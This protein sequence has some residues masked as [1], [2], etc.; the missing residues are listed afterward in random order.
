MGNELKWRPKFKNQQNFI[1]TSI[2]IQIALLKMFRKFQNRDDVQNM[3]YKRWSED[4]KEK[5][6]AV[7]FSPHDVS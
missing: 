5:L 3:S 2:F 4:C 1:F 7:C 6:A